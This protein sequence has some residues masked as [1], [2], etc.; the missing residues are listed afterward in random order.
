MKKGRVD[1][2]LVIVVT[3]LLAAGMVMVFSSSSMIAV[4]KYGSLTHFFLKQMMWSAL[5]LLLMILFSN[6]NYKTL[7]K[8]KFPEAGI[9][10]SFLLLIGLFVLGVKMNGAR[11]WYDL[12]VGSFQPSELTKLAVIVYF[13]FYL[14]S[15]KKNIRNMKSGLLPLLG[16]LVGLM[17]LIAVQPDLSTALMLGVVGGTLLLISR[18]KLSHLALLSLPLIPAVI[19]GINRQGFRLRRLY[20]WL[21]GW[22]NPLNAGYQIKQSLIGLGRGGMFG[23]NLGQSKQKFLFLPDSHTDFIFSIIGE[24]WGFIGTTLILIAFMIIFYRGLVI[25]RR[26]PDP[27]GKFLAVGIVLNITVYA[28]INAAVVSMLVPATGLPMPFISYG[29]SNLLFLGAAMGILLNIS[30]QMTPAG[31]N[32]GDF[33][34]NRE[35]Y[36]KTVIAVD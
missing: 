23:Q 1:L 11:R 30:R 21:A 9:V 16:I 29:G 18:A 6:I 3:F 32:Y 10:I 36:L 28:L 27:F 26:V 12:G 20:E 14:S 13:A 33:K 7:K 22:D 34:Q 15:S 25:A 24:E 4:N 31:A 17:V 8:Y 2:T 5:A 19:L 35:R